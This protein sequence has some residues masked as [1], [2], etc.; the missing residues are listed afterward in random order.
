M[1]VLVLSGCGMGAATV[2]SADLP[3]GAEVEADLV[4]GGTTGI[5]QCPGTGWLDP[6]SWDGLA[7]TYTRAT[8]APA[9]EFN[10]VTISGS[11]AAFR[12]SRLVG[13][14]FQ[15]GPLKALASNPAIG[16]AWAFDDDTG[17]NRDLYFTPFLQRSASTGRVMAVCAGKSTGSPFFMLK[18]LY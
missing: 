16:P 10:S 18:R 13:T 2:D 6:A 8:L 7:G 4:A 12:Y 14:G 11:T 17:K 3:A 9:S 15:L 5:A 1:A